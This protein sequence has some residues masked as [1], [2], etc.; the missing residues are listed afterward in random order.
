MMHR[1]TFLT[2]SIL[3][4][5]GLPALTRAASGSVLRFG[6]ITD[7]HQD[8]MHDAVERVTAFVDAMIA[9]KADFIVQLGDFC[10]PLERNRAFLAAWNR[11]PGPRRHVLGNHDMDGGMKR[12]EAVAF[13]GMPSRYYAFDAGGVRFVVLDGNDPGGLV[14][15]LGGKPVIN[16]WR[17][18]QR[19]GRVMATAGEVLPVEVR[20]FKA[21]ARRIAGSTG[22]GRGRSA[23]SRGGVYTFRRRRA[24]R[25]GA[26]GGTGKTERARSGDG[27]SAARAAAAHGM[28]CR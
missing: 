8:I 20:F 28:D 17:G 15:S 27:D 2:H 5:T 4:V 16:G 1:R 26:R 23:C 6:I 13:L 14:V 7:L 11:F 21:A 18:S 19:E 3:T 12:E 25:G 10:I 22:R 24:A 9:A